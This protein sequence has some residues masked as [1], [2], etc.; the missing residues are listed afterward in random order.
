MNNILKVRVPFYRRVTNNTSDGLATFYLKSQPTYLPTLNQ[1]VLVSHTQVP[2][3]SNLATKLTTLSTNTVGALFQ[4][5]TNNSDTT[6]IS[7][8]D[9]YSNFFTLKYIDNKFSL[10]IYAGGDCYG[11]IEYD[12]NPVS[13]LSTLKPIEA[14]VV[15]NDMVPY[16]LQ[17][18]Y[19]FLFASRNGLTGSTENCAPMCFVERKATNTIFANTLKGLNLPVSDLELLKYS[20]TKWGYPTTPTSSQT[21]TYYKN[22]VPFYWNEIT[23]STLPG[24]VSVNDILTHPVT[25]TTGEHYNTAMQSIGSY[26]F[27]TDYSKTPVP[28]DM[29]LIMEIP[30]KTYGEIIDGKSIKILM[31][32]WTGATPASTIKQYL[33]IYPTYTVAPQIIELYGTYNKSGLNVYDLDAV[34]SEKDLT[35]KDLGAKAD[36]STA[37]SNYESNVVL[38][39]SDMFGKP[40]EN[41]T[42]SW[43]DGHADVIDGIK[44]FNPSSR[45]KNLYNNTNDRCVGVAFLDKGFV[46]ITHPKIVDSFY[47]NAFNGH[48]TTGGT[49]SAPV[50]VYDNYGVAALNTNLYRHSTSSGAGVRAYTGNTTNFLITRNDSNQVEWDSTQF[51][52]TGTTGVP[53]PYYPNI[54]FLSY[55]SE[56]SLNIVCLASS[57][58]FFTTTNDTAKDLMNVDPSADYVSFKT[59]NQNLNPVIITQLGIHDADGNLLAICK[60]TQPISKYWYDVVS[61]NVKIRL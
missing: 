5:Y 6:T 10:D 7:Q 11:Y 12:V 38:L 33:G 14:A 49:L 28:N 24:G 51:V 9:Y 35:M 15:V 27:I 47:V 21:P 42:G 23:T 29:F 44:A 60:P 25:G 36:L 22:G 20:R 54:E 56:K 57:D 48:I 30:P 1:T 31:P 8:T 32:Y 4:A 59:N 2:S 45:S 40:S 43:N 52:Y 41:P 26:E 34:L 16:D 58:E 61:F 17:E 3:G 50:K 37:L 55:N 53:H 46:V 39:F 13:T 19:N 18:G